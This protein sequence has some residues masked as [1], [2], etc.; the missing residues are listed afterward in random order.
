MFI[1]MLNYPANISEFFAGL[2][3]LITFDLFP[4]DDIY[5]FLFGYEELQADIELNQQFEIVGYEYTFMVGNMGSMF[6]MMLLMPVSALA[7][8]II[9]KCVPHWFCRQ[10]GK[11]RIIPYIQKS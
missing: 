3:P 8:F 11:K 5:E 1:L 10:F 2:F 6:I 4:T 7:Y 9:L